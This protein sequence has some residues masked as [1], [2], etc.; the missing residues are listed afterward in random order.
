MGLHYGLVR[1][2]NQYSCGGRTSTAMGLFSIYL[3]SVE[4]YDC[5]MLGNRV[6]EEERLV[7]CGHST[8]AYK[9]R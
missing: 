2:P 4:A 5:D 3:L 7:C 8:L 9:A 1:Y 6:I